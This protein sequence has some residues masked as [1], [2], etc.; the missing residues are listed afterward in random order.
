MYSI[1]CVATECILE[2]Y[3]VELEDLV[4]GTQCNIVITCKDR[5]VV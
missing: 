3:I 4:M 1:E 5:E 2:E